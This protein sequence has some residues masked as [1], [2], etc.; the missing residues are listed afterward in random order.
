M[1][2]KLVETGMRGA[3][4]NIQMFDDDLAPIL[5]LEFED[6]VAVAGLGGANGEQNAMILFSQL[7]DKNPKRYLLV[8][9]TYVANPAKGS[10][11]Y[12]KLIDSTVQ[13]RDLPPDDRYDAVTIL[14]VENG[15]S[16]HSWMGRIESLP[17]GKR[18]IPKWEP[19]TGVMGGR[20]AIPSW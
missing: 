1:T 13:V 14:L 7:K 17:N 5:I 4:Y 2:D 12:K 18:H 20:L 16:M 9:E 15:V 11:T 3:E 10:K 6:N 19:G 8:S